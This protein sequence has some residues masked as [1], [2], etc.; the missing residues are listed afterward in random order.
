LFS[1]IASSPRL[2]S[3]IAA[4]G[5]E[6]IASASAKAAIQPARASALVAQLVVQDREVVLRHH[7][8][9]AIAGGAAQ[10]EGLAVAVEGGLVL[11]ARLLHHA[12][13]RQRRG[14][15]ALVA[16]LAAAGSASVIL[17]NASS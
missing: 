9:P 3:T 13:V 17:L 14:D 4:S 6:P 5:S 2:T 10:L 1:S 16:T 15:R 7:R 8:A 12:E 11:A